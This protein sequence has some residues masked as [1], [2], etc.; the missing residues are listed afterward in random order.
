MTIPTINFKFNSLPEAQA[1]S[2]IVEQKLTALEKYLSDARSIQCDVEFEK[3]APRQNGQIHRLGVN[4]V[5]D[6]AVFWA[7]AVEE[8]FEK[9]IDQVRDDLDRELRQAKEIAETKKRQ[10]GR[11]AKE[12]LQE[13]D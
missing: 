9:A 8:S 3:T 1:L 4:M 2:D 6:G 10:G 13:I 11:E 5:V 7:E 12:Q